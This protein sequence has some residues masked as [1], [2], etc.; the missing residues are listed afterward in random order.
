MKK[1]LAILFSV[2]A[3]AAQAQIVG[4]LPF[5]LQNNTTADATQVMADFNKILNDVNAN[6]AKNGVNSDITALTALVTPITPTA[7]G[8]SV[9]FA[10]TSTGTANAQVIAAPV[11]S[12]FTLGVGKRITFVAGFTN[13]AATQINVNGTGL[14]DVFRPTPSGP[15]A[16]TGGEIIAG[17]YI[18]A[19]YDG[20]QFQLY[21]NAAQQSFG[22]LTSLASAATTD[23]GTIGSHN[24]NITGVTGITS[25]GSTAITAW[26]V[27]K[28]T[29]A[30]VLTITHNGTS[31]ILPGGAGITTAAND[32]AE[33]VYLGSGNWRMT[34]YTRATGVAT[35]NPNLIRGYIDGLTLSISSATAI[36]T[37]AGV[38]VDS[39]NSTSMVLA[40]P[41]TKTT[42]S[43]TVGTGNGGLD[44]G[45]IAANTW[46]H[47]YEIERPDTGVIDIAFSLSA[48]AP[49]TGGT[50]PAA[51]TLFRRI[52][53][54]RTNGSSQWT[55]FT[56]LGD[57]FTWSASVTD[58]NA[59]APP[60]IRVQPA[61]TV[62]TGVPVTALFRAVLS[63]SSASTNGVIFTSA[64]ESDQAPVSGA[65]SDLSWLSNGSAGVSMG[66]FSRTTDTLARIGVR[67]A[68]TGGTYSIFTYGWIDTR[69]KS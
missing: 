3:C 55:A 41:I 21:T 7:G 26:P 18:E 31:L 58:V 69:G 13:T 6:A 1:L 50:I 27:Y 54:A 37:A 34:S 33:V 40:A 29:F 25:F 43:W 16:L 20:T 47:F 35:V 38:A 49:T 39:T 28:L 8:S 61:L 5:Q 59:V 44:T 63:L 45:A 12:G 46:Y 15:V 48:S 9:Y 14:T 57:Q 42:A 32:T 19:V 52:G 23:I 66:N 36:A 17:N 51:Y 65:F 10:S 60:T 4:T 22:P 24:V 64:L 53:A 2:W 11:P 56:Q 30:G 62:P 67:G 68:N